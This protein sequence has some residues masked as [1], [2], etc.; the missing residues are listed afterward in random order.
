MIDD[1]NMTHHGQLY[2]IA[3]KFRKSGATGSG[4][5]MQ[6][7]ETVEVWKETLSRR[8]QEVEHWVESQPMEPWR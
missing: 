4:P 2:R 7:R 1:E 8:Y 5:W 6:N 3:W